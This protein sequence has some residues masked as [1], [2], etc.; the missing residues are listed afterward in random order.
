MRA[1]GGAGRRP[2]PRRVPYALVVETRPRRPA[3][4]PGNAAFYGRRR[5]LAR[6]RRRTRRL[7]VAGHNRGPAAD[8]R[9]P[10]PSVGTVRR[11]DT[12]RPVSSRRRER[13]GRVTR[14]LCRRGAPLT[15]MG[16]RLSARRY[17]ETG[18]TAPRSPAATAAPDE[19][20]KVGEVRDQGRLLSRLETTERLAYGRLT[21]A[22][23]RRTM[24]ALPR[25]LAKGHAQTFG[26][27]KIGP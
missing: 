16:R 23:S 11:A 3:T 24:P 18:N 5:G 15:A 26:E 9:P 6:R 14:P 19:E 4:P 22:A 10:P 13:E 7:R 17:L 21:A 1:V 25:L 8:G 2:S 27:D 20:V 12:R